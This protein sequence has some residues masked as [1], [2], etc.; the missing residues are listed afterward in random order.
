MQTTIGESVLQVLYRNLLKV[1]AT[2]SLF[3][4]RAQRSRRHPGQ[5]LPEKDAGV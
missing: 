2:S 5:G 1:G 3:R 4:H